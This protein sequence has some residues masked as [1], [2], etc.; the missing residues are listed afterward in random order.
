M[1]NT[2]EFTGKKPTK[3]QIIKRAKECADYGHANISIVWGE[4]FIDLSLSG[5]HGPWHGY[6]WLK[7]ISGDDIAKQLNVSALFDRQMGNPI[8]FLR[9][10]VQI[11]HIGG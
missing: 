5:A 7:D 8:K 3:A 1:D 9:D 10:H 2:I 11:M 4:N 6:G